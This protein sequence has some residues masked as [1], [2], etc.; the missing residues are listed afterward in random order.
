MRKRIKGKVQ[1]KGRVFFRKREVLTGGSANGKDQ[2]M[3]KR[4]GE[5][6]GKGKRDARVTYILAH[7]L[8]IN[9]DTISDP[10]ETKR[11][12]QDV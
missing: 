10:V 1:K 5:G 11:R 9:P 3:A 4:V 8:V 6:V 12:L 7:V 2:A